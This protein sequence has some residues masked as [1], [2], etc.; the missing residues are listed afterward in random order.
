MKKLAKLVVEWAEAKGLNK[1][2]PNAQ[3]K[4]VYEE[5]GETSAALLLNDMPEII[6][7]IGDVYVTL[8]VLSNQLNIPFDFNDKDEIEHISENRA[9]IDLAF[10]VGNIGHHIDSESNYSMGFVSHYIYLA[11]VA[12]S[13]LAKRRGLTAEQCLQT[14]YDVISK[15]KGKMVGDVFIKEKPQADWSKKSGK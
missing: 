3:F 2:N 4:K 5:I 13:H 14:A 7:G 1:A 9:F 12:L 8:I 6:D 10:C 11:C 15:R